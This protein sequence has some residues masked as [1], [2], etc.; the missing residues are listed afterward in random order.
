[1]YNW[2]DILCPWIR[3]LNIVKMA[4]LYKLLYR[5]L[6]SKSPVNFFRYKEA[7]YKAC[8]ERQRNQK[9]KKK[10]LKEE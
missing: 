8:I 6:Q 9:N 7:D 1:M 4:I 5:K 2:R 3:R 10:I